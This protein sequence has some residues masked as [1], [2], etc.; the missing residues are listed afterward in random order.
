MA[1]RRMFSLDVIDTDAFLDMPVS[2]QN[3]YFHLGMRADDDGFV[4]NPKKILKLI[5]C[6]EDDLKLLYT[7]NYIKIFENGIL[8]ITHWHQNNYI[9]KD[10]YT[11]TV[12]KNEKQLLKISENGSYVELQPLV[13]QMVD[14][15]ATQYRLGKVSIGKYSVEEE[16]KEESDSCDDGFNKVVDFYNNNIGL[17]TPYTRDLL[18]DYSKNMENDVIIYALQLAVEANVRTVK[19]IKA[20]LNDWEKR[21]IKTLIEAQQEN[22]THKNQKNSSEETQEEKNARRKKEIEEAMKNDATR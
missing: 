13:Y 16:V 1:N 15:M 19:Y 9:R 14:N 4:S 6:N 10:R 17:I 22:K 18:L 2:T 3:L 11:E 7:K 21:G 20:I 8:V 12:Y 5:G